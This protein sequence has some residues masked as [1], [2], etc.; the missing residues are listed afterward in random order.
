MKR[1]R[2]TDDDIND[3]HIAIEDDHVIRA[4]EILENP[5]LPEYIIECETFPEKSPQHMD[6]GPETFMKNYKTDI[7]DFERVNIII[8]YEDDEILVWNNGFEE[9][10]IKLTSKRLLELRKL[11]LL[12]RNSA[13]YYDNVLEAT[14]ITDDYNFKPCRIVVWGGHKGQVIYY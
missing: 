9:A 14:R 3:L 12:S 13:Y 5:N 11:F 2:E 8:T 6:V 1:Q 4:L 7:V 10:F